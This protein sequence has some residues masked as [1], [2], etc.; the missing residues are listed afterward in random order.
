MY[1]LQRVEFYHKKCEAHKDKDGWR[2]TLPKSK[3]PGFTGALKRF[4][5]TIQ[6]YF[7]GLSGT[8]LRRTS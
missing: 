5:F 3:S 2:R 6:R 7:L 8:P 4:L 1:L